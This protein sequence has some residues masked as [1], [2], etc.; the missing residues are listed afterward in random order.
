MPQLHLPA[1]LE[2]LAVVNSFLETNV[3][4][5]FRAQLPNVELAAEELLVNVF[6]YAYPEGSEGMA[7]VGLREVSF[8]GRAM[9]CFTV[10]DWGAPFDPFAEAPA[11]DLSLD[12]ESRPIGG[13]GVFLIR[14]VT[15]HQAYSREGDANII[16]VYFALPE[17]E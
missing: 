15:A 2:Q 16:D 12:T 4:A 17:R 5:A 10:K 1:T 7:E 3:P 9:L 13:L 8:D 6:S 14:S 11:P